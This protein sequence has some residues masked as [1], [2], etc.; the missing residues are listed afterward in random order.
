MKTCSWI[1]MIYTHLNNIIQ[2]IRKETSIAVDLF[3]FYKRICTLFVNTVKTL[4]Q[5]KITLFFFFLEPMKEVLGIW[6][7]K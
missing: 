4:P 3:N 1:F 5:L 7:K 6:K 2:Y